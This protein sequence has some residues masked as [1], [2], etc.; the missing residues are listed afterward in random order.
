MITHR[1]PSPPAADDA[2]V[3]K[4]PDTESIHD[5]IVAEGHVQLSRTTAALAWSAL[6]AGL[7]MGF[8]LIAEAGL[9]AYLPDAPWRPLL[10][11]FGYSVG[12]LIVILARQQLFTEI[13]L[14]PVLAMLERRT[15]ASVMG[16]ARV[17][18]TVL[19]GNLLGALAFALMIVHTSV[20]SSELQ[21]AVREISHPA[22]EPEFGVVFLRGIF[23]GWLMALLV[24]LLPA[25]K[26]ARVWIIIMMTWVIGLGHFSHVISGSLEVFALAAANELDWAR[27][28]VGF[29]LPALVGNI[30]GG[31]TLVAF[32]NHAQ[33]ASDR[34]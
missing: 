15:S 1:K 26:S 9:H 20:I 12:F 14:T 34:D 24:W 28:L 11:N 19:A 32:L 22:I 25:A 30:V 23:G 31:V 5:V 29:T 27:A 21:A 18:S 8:S 16:V 2:D 33:V 10:S 3:R 6:A 7:S 4:S 17:W 13:T